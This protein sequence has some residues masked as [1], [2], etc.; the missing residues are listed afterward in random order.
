MASKLVARMSAPDELPPDEAGRTQA[1]L[2]AARSAIL[3][4]RRHAGAHDAVLAGNALRVACGHVG[5]R[6]G[7][8][9]SSD[10]LERLFSR[11]CVGK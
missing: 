8:L 5:G 11:F 4:A 6:I 3:A 10:M 7:G 1:A 9:Y 2:L